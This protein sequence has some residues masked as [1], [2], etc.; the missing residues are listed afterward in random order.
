MIDDD[1]IEMSFEAS[2]CFLESLM[3]SRRYVSDALLSKLDE[4]ILIELELA[5]M[6]ASKAKSEILKQNKPNTTVRPIK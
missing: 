4:V 5:L 1:D 3:R 6:G 2:G